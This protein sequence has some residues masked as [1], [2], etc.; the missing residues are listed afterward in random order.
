MKYFYILLL[1]TL[2][3]CCHCP[4]IAYQQDGT[5]YKV[6]VLLENVDK[7]SKEKIWF[8]IDTYVNLFKRYLL[9]IR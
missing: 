5:D 1:L 7:G 9:E 2:G 4:K 6:F 8:P 3:S